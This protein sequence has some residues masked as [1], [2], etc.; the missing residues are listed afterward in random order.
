MPYER[1]RRET[2]CLLRSDSVF[3][4]LWEDSH[5]GGTIPKVQ[6]L[7]PWSALCHVLAPFWG[8]LPWHLQTLGEWLLQSSQPLPGDEEK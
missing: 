4:T 7:F 6:I 8:P 5:A 3:S 1:S 2:N